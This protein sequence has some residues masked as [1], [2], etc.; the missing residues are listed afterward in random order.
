M[1]FSDNYYALV[2]KEK[3]KKKKKAAEQK[4]GHSFTDNYNKAM[5]DSDVAPVKTVSTDAPL[6]QTRLRLSLRETFLC[7]SRQL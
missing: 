6:L 1:S 4:T 5:A 3:K 2:E 7:L